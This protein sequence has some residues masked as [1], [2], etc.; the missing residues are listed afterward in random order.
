MFRRP[1]ARS[2]GFALGVLFGLS[3]VS[4]GSGGV[5]DNG[6]F[7]SEPAKK[8]AT[9]KI[10]EIEKQYKKELVIETF[11]T[12]P[13]DVTQGIDL[14]D[15]PARNKMFEQW[16]VKEARQQ[17]VN[18]IFVLLSREP[19]HLHIV[20]GN[21]TQNKAFTLTDRDNLAKLMLDKM[22]AKR[23]DEALTECVKFVGTTIAGHATHVAPSAKHNNATATPSS[24]L[25]TGSA[26]PWG[27]IITAVVGLAVV[28]LIVGVLRS[29]MGRSGAGAGAGMM[30]GASGGGM[31][32]SLLGGMFGAAAGM[33][34]YDQFSG[35]HGNAWGGDQENRDVGSTGFSGED[36][37]YSGT[38]GDFS[39]DTGGGDSGGDYGGGGDF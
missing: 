28:W 11:T 34:L 18:G 37:D 8:E 21:E 39:S 32:N 29:F 1:L 15:I 27:W 38:G 23:N 9:R 13:E 3:V 2:I 30:P 31:F 10:L 33:W 22:R 5:R 24:S 35:N 25:A 36:T 16:A 26:S 7:F 6:D 4:A 17:K 12:I 14:T 19:A 20:V